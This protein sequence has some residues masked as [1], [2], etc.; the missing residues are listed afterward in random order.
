MAAKRKEGAKKD[1]E[2]GEAKRRTRDT[3]SQVAHALR[4]RD[5]IVHSALEFL[6]GA[7]FLEDETR[8]RVQETYELGDARTRLAIQELLGRVLKVPLDR[9]DEHLAEGQVDPARI[10]EA[11]LR[12]LEALALPQ[13]DVEAVVGRIRGFDLDRL[14]ARQDSKALRY[15][16][17]IPVRLNRLR[18]GLLFG[19]IAVL[20]LVT[21]A[22]LFPTYTLYIFLYGALALLA[23]LGG[24]MVTWSIRLERGAKALGIDLVVFSR[25][26]PEER[27]VLVAR[28]VLVHVLDPQRLGDVVEKSLHS[29]LPK[30]MQAPSRGDVVPEPKRP[31]PA[32]PRPLAAEPPPR[33]QGPSEGT[34]PGGTR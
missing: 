31:R 10:S 21:L 17:D 33:D 11:S 6:H 34:P 5:A 25:L 24:L 20:L 26:S 27:R 16:T 4:H 14:V 28:R 3:V 23:V 30:R 13:I 19:G 29:V 9:L 7:G 22:L 1:A 32:R 15:V 2:D 12:D 18:L 8:R